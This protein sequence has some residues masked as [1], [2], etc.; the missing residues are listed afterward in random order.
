MQQ[1]WSRHL[2]YTLAGLAGATLAGLYMGYPVYG[3]T[4]GLGI[5]VLWTLNQTRRLAQWLVE[6]DATNEAP[7]SLGMWGD[8]F[9]KLHKL[10]QNL[11]TLSGS[12]AGKNR[13]HTRIHK[14]Y[15]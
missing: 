12:T 7:Q 8:L 6:P 4:A 5:Y 13:P 1:T 14:R 10:N 2:R 9:E 11:P 15:A 3:L